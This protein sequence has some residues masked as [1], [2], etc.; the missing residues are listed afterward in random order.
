MYEF[1]SLHLAS[2]AAAQRKME[3]IVRDVRYAENAFRAIRYELHAHDPTYFPAHRTAEED[4]VLL[5][6]E[7]LRIRIPGGGP[8]YAAHFRSASYL[9][10]V[11]ADDEHATPFLVGQP[12]GA[13]RPYLVGSIPDENAYFLGESEALDPFI[14]PERAFEV[15]DLRSQLYF[16]LKGVDSTATFTG[17][18]LHAYG[19]YLVG[20]SKYAMHFAHMGTKMWEGVRALNLEAALALYISTRLYNATSVRYGLQPTTHAP[21]LSAYFESGDIQ[22]EVTDYPMQGSLLVPEVGGHEAHVELAPWK[23]LESLAQ[24]PVALALTG[25]RLRVFVGERVIAESG[26]QSNFEATLTLPADRLWNTLHCLTGTY[27]SLGLS[28]DG[29]FLVVR[30]ESGRKTAF[31]SLAP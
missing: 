9:L 4:A 5:H 17:E 19:E 22:I 18:V 3:D 7:H 23:V 1:S 27:V 30:E 13:K 16:A 15:G 25:D 11:L 29:A 26:A 21:V 8:D 31:L 2:P 12:L 24:A 28:K 6:N 14:I 20:S 10:T